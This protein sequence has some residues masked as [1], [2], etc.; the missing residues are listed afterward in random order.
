VQRRGLADRRWHLTFEGN[1]GR[2]TSLYETLV[3]EP[4][5]GISTF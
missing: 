2:I 1:I 5:V 3:R 4:I